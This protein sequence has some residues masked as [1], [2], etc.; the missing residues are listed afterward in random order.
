[1]REKIVEAALR[2]FSHYSASKTTMNEIADDLHCS[3]AS[4]YYYFPDK[5]ALHIAVLGKV[6]DT[7]FQEMEVEVANMT[8]AEAA[9]RKMIETRL[10]FA[11]RFCRLELFKVLRDKQFLPT[12]EV[13]IKYRE[14]ELGL[15]VSI[16]SKGVE[17]GELKAE[18][19]EKVA[20]LYM[21]ASIG[22]RMSLT[23]RRDKENI[24]EEE[25]AEVQRWQ[26]DLLDIF[27]KALK[28]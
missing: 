17:M 10:V 11:Q 27:I 16:I 24:T 7:Y 8:S 14:R 23:A 6:G 21:E 13:Y 15:L 9:L 25:F 2:R 4:L 20:R 28:R 3:K 26:C 1:M 12:D 18:Q 19:P 5:L 22:L